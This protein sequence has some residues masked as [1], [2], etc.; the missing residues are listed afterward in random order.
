[1]IQSMT[2]F[3]GRAEKAAGFGK[4]SV[5]LR[6]ANHKFLETVLHLPPGFLSLEGRIR[7]EIENKIRRG[8]VVCVVNLAGNEA[9]AVLVNQGLLKNYLRALKKIKTLYRLQDNPRLDTLINLPGV[10]SLAESGIP[11]EKI[12]PHLKKLLDQALRDLVKMRQKEGRALVGYLKTKTQ[13][14]QRILLALNCR[15]R[16]VVKDK[17]AKIAIEE[18]R[19]A[20]LKDSDITEEVERLEF[21]LRNFLQKLAQSSPVG[22]ELDF[23]AQEMQREANTIGAKSCDKIISAW[24]IQLKSQIEKLR[25]QI[26]NIE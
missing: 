22:K 10:L 23:I 16:K 26:Q 20:F 1:M 9:G 13:A 25:E 11:K 17:A 3:G 7:K 5:E 14:L 4:I 24:V 15:F 12:W 19:S 6:S 2:G 21:H 8:R 18:E